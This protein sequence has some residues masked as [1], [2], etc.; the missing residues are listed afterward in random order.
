MVKKNKTKAGDNLQIIDAAARL[1]D[2]ANVLA[3]TTMDEMAESIMAISNSMDRIMNDGPFK[4]RVLLKIIVDAIPTHRGK[5]V[6]GMKDLEKVLDIIIEL[7]Q[8]LLK[9]GD[10][11]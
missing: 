9:D 11:D 3:G 4:K 7:P 2:A 8:H 6:I 1:G 5:Q 10:D